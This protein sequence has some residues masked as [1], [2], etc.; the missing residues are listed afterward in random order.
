VSLFILT[1]LAGNAEAVYNANLAGQLD[2]FWAYSDG[3]YILFRLKNQPATHPTCNPSF[4][5]IPDTVPA[6]RRKMM[7]ARLSLAYATQESV[8][9]GYDN[10]GDCASGYIHVHRVG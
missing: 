4:F 10:V 8:N 5:V 7:F 2:G 1:A 9:I 6:D 3:D